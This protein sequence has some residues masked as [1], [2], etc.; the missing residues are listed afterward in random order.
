MSE[1]YV[2]V[3]VMHD[4]NESPPVLTVADIRDFL[5][6]YDDHTRDLA[7]SRADDAEDAAIVVRLH[8]N[9][10]LAQGKRWNITS[11]AAE[12]HE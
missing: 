2:Q 8:E 4:G 1:V 5:A 7:G 6:R 10:V 3:R 12:A 9:Q 11:I